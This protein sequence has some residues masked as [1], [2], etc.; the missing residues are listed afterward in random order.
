MQPISGLNSG[1]VQLSAPVTGGGEPAK[2]QRPEGGGQEGARRPVTD[3]YVLEERREPSGRYWP[4]RDGEGR[5]GIR[6]DS[7]ERPEESR[8]TADTG[9]V[10]REIEALR[11]KLAELERRLS[12]ETDETRKKELEA[13]VARTESELVQK[14]NDAYRRRN[15]EYTGA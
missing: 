1:G 7:P 3:E 6:F 10:D 13:E 15:T 11:R 4:D 5:P 12:A 2:T 14:D 8:C 9:K